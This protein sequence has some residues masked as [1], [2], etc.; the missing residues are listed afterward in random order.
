MTCGLRQTLLFSLIWIVSG[1]DG[2][3]EVAPAYIS[4]S[5]FSFEIRA[6]EGTQRQNITDGWIYVG[7]QYVGAYELPAI[8]PLLNN[9]SAEVRILPGYRQD[10]RIT[11]AYR[12]A[13]LEPYVTQANFAAL[14]TTDIV[15]VTRYQSGLKF[16]FIEG[17]DGAHFFNT[18]RD[19]DPETKIQLTTS[20]DAFEGSRSGIIELTE[21]HS[22]LTCV[23]DIERAI[24]QSPDPIILELHFKSD[25]PF[26]IGFI[27][28]KGIGGED[29][30]IQATLLPKSEWT[31]VYFDYREII[32]LSNAISYRLAIRANYQSDTPLA[33][34]RISIDNVKVIHR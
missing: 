9:G 18:D 21:Q 8:I 20:Q 27:G 7:G 34:Q 4:V 17:F 22:S 5:P 11:N 2:D 3:Q 23:Y 28:N 10:G 26:S 19:N 12:Y 15:P 6:G 29:D 31:K 32:N 1:C 33:T 30:L 14:D 24:P 25:I 16:P 13:L